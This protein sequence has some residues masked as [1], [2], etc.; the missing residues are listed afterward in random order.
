MLDQFPNRFQSKPD[1]IH[2]ATHCARAGGV[3]LCGKSA[4]PILPPVSFLAGGDCIQIPGVVPG[5]AADI[6]SREKVPT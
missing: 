5:T 6:A 3:G 2:P 1:T 4:G